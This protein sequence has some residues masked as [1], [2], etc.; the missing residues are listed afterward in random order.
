VPWTTDLT[1][2]V[3]KGVNEVTVHVDGRDWDSGAP[4]NRPRLES[5][6]GIDYWQPAGLTRMA[7]LHVVPDVHVSDVYAQPQH[8]LDA[9]K[10]S[11]K[12]TAWIGISTS[13][14]FSPVSFALI[15]CATDTV[16][17]VQWGTA[18]RNVGTT[19]T[20]LGAIRLW[21]T[22]QPNLYRVNVTVYAS[23]GG[24]NNT[25]HTRS[26]RFGFRDVRFAHDGFFL[27]GERVQLIGLSRAQFFPFAG[28]AQPARV[29]R[30]DV[31]LLKRYCNFVRQSH[32]PQD[33]AFLDAADELG[34]L[35]WTEIPGWCGNQEIP[36][37]NVTYRSLVLRDT[38]AMIKR[39]RNHPSVVVWGVRQNECPDDVLWKATEAVAKSLDSRATSG[40]ICCQYGTSIYQ[41]VFAYNDYHS[42][43]VDGLRL[44]FLAPPLVNASYHAYMVSEAVGALSGP[45][46]RY[47]RSDAVAVQQDQAIAHAMVHNLAHTSRAYCGLVAWCAMDY[48]SGCGALTRPDA[49]KTIGVIDLFRIPKLG[50]AFYR[51]AVSSNDTVVIEPSFYFRFDGQFDVRSLDA[52]LI[53]TNAKQLEV[54]ADSVSIAGAFR[55][56]ASFVF[57]T[58]NMQSNRSPR[59][60][61]FL[62]CHFLHLLLIPASSHPAQRFCR[63]LLLGLSIAWLFVYL[64]SNASLWPLP[65]RPPSL[66][67]REMARA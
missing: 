24:S 43:K 26:I 4:P 67:A 8:V 9:K 33:P 53:W 12:V 57:S 6:E 37:A 52:A 10:R 60:P 40:A 3:L 39:D 66:Q 48:P 47:R 56:F 21:S 46:A 63:F 50:A 16:L 5:A 7:Q 1:P 28:A 32:Y 36:Q 61:G 14:V 41:D 58:V 38:A 23:D 18:A 25:L 65:T 2:V 27:N 51:S 55:A 49:T 17:A 34:L 54:V 15:D 59:I 31:V 62:H 29:Q 19:F 42:H 30:D 45:F 35:V 22:M 20:D 64:I 13:A 44:P 11:L